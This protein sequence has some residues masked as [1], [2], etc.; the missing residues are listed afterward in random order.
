MA[1][2]EQSPRRGGLVLSNFR[3]KTLQSDQNHCAEA[4]RAAGAVVSIAGATVLVESARR[5]TLAMLWQPRKCFRRSG[6][7]KRESGRAGA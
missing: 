3:A 4:P 2:P 6:G 1:P 5:S 7:D